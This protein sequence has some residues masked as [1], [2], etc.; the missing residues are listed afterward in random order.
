MHLGEWR[1]VHQRVR[2]LRKLVSPGTETLRHG[3]DVLADR[4]PLVVLRPPEHPP[5]RPY[6]ELRGLRDKVLASGVR[7]VRAL[8]PPELAAHAEQRQRV[9]RLRQRPPL[10]ILHAEL[11]KEAGTDLLGAG[12]ALA[13]DVP[14]QAPEVGA[15]VQ[16]AHDGA[17]KLLAPGMSPDCGVQL[18]P[19]LLLPL[20][21]GAAVL[22]VVLLGVVGALRR[23]LEVLPVRAVQLVPP[24]TAVGGVHVRAAI[25]AV[26]RPPR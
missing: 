21:P 4:L 5:E 7:G 16:P 10:K 8:A 12:P 26:R 24:D 22:L 3:G 13:V 11:G 1:P 18:G 9:G 15:V 2:A 17:L 6:L 14:L 25:D 23:P 19:P 20:V